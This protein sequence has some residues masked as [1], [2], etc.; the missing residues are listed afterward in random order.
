MV[1]EFLDEIIYKL[2]K[3]FKRVQR[4]YIIKGFTHIV[5]YFLFIV[6]VKPYGDQ[7]II[8]QVTFLQIGVAVMVS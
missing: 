1:R 5:H 8:L 6:W 7:E 4:G 3:D 2:I